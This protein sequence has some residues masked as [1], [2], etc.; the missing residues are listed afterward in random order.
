M[1]CGCVPLDLRL[2]LQKCQMSLPSYN[3]GAM[4]LLLQGNSSAVASSAFAAP[5]ATMAAARASSIG[6]A[7]GAPVRAC[8][9]DGIGAGAGYMGFRGRGAWTSHDR[10]LKGATCPHHTLTAGHTCTAGWSVSSVK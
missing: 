10:R 6:R 5:A 2:P 8:M 9:R 3:A 4:L 7:G 1:L